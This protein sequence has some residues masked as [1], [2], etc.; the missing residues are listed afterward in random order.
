VGVVLSGVR[1]LH[2]AVA[3]GDRLTSPGC[4]HAMPMSVGELFHIDCYDLTLG[5]YDM[6]LDV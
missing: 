3:N 5:S 1:D 2:V 4:C 6:V